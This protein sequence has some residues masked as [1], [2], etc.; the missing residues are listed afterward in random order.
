[1]PSGTPLTAARFSFN[2]ERLL[3]SEGYLLD[4]CAEM[5]SASCCNTLVIQ[6]DNLASLHANIKSSQNHLAVV[7]GH[8]TKALCALAATYDI[9]VVR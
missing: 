5:N 6:T 8:H 3:V 4:S 1:M 7:V 2:L 9:P